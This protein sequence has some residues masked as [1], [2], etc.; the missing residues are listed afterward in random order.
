MFLELEKPELKE[1]PVNR[2]EFARY[3]LAKVHIDYHV[4]VNHNFYSVPYEYVGKE[5]DL[6]ISEK[7]IEVFFGGRRVSIHPRY[8]AKYKNQYHTRKE[9]MPSK[10][11]YMEEW[12]PA[13]FLSWAS[14]IGPETQIQINSVLLCR[15]AIEQ[16]YRSCIAILSL[17]KKY[18]NY[19]LETACKKANDFGATSAR[20][21]KNILENNT[22]GNQA[23]EQ[24]PI[25]HSNLRRDVEFH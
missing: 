25:F 4:Q 23:V 8:L 24:Q 12:S 15:R 6:R 11:R 22:E 18:G 17:S 21:I 9:H 7:A 1:L 19:R 10:H 14:A 2:Y 5:V 13:R 20:S 3:K 16:S